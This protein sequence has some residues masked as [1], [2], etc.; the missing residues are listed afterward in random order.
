M[1]HDHPTFAAV[2]DEH[3]KPL[4][5]PDDPHVKLS[6]PRPLSDKL[7]PLEQPQFVEMHEH[8]ETLT[9]LPTEIQHVADKH[10]IDESVAGDRVH[11]VATVAAANHIVQK[12]SETFRHKLSHLIV[13]LINGIVQLSEDFEDSFP[14]LLQAV[15][16][17][18]KAGSSVLINKLQSAVYGSLSKTAHTVDILDEAIKT[19]EW[20]KGHVKNVHETAGELIKDTTSHDTLE[21]LSNV[22]PAII[23]T[24]LTV[25]GG[26]GRL[27]LN[28]SVVKEEVDK[29][30]FDL[31]HV[32][33]AEPVKDV[34]NDWKELK[35]RAKASHDKYLGLKAT[36]VGQK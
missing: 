25:Q 31:S 18:N 35:I 10:E 15:G 11:D 23:A 9:G 17:K 33:D 6:P 30:H 7:F 20:G 16:S 34:V 29:G 5:L 24:L 19:V 22:K 8:G 3:Y 36:I 21:S 14:K 26:F 12:H 13:E 2:L 32:F 1:S 27:L 28:L 4:E